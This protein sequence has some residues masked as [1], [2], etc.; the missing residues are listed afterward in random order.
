[1]DVLSRWEE[2]WRLLF[3]SWRCNLWV[4]SVGVVHGCGLWGHLWVWSVGSFMGVVNS[5]LWVWFMGVVFRSVS[6]S[7]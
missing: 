5:C 3:S 6:W 2:H 4:W 7:K 1:M